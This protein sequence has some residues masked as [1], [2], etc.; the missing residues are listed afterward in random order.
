MKRTTTFEALMVLCGYKNPSAQ[1]IYWRDDRGWTLPGLKEEVEA[2]PLINQILPLLHK[3]R[4][5]ESTQRA[6]QALEGA[7][8]DLA[9]PA[10]EPLSYERAL[11]SFV[12]ARPLIGSLLQ[13][14]RLD[15]IEGDIIYVSFT[16]GSLEAESITD[17]AKVTSIEG[18][19]SQCAGRLIRFAFTVTPEEQTK[20]SPV[21]PP[22]PPTQEI[23]PKATHFLAAEPTHDTP[24]QVFG[25]LFDGHK[26]RAVQG[27]TPLASVLDVLS[28]LGY[29]D[30]KNTF[31]QI[32]DRTPGLVEE[33][34]TYSFGPGQPTPV[35]SSKT[36]L[37]IL[38]AAPNPPDRSKLVR[39]RE[40]AAKTLD[41]VVQG[42][43]TL[44]E[45]IRERG[46]Q[47]QVSALQLPQESRERLS[48]L[49]ERLA[50]RLQDKV[51]ETTI[52][53][54]LIR[55]AELIEGRSLTAIRPKAIEGRW[56]TP[57]QIA[58]KHGVRLYDVGAIIKQ[59]GLK[60]DGE[61]G[62]DGLS[63]PYHTTTEGGTRDVVCF[64]YTETAMQRI[65]ERIQPYQE[66]KP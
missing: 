14:G 13:R 8:K 61:R 27:E 37:K 15:K 6:I 54:I 4:R 32:K 3:M 47:R 34:S 11:R 58:E 53:N 45:E 43:V 59:L 23:A 60:G 40:W 62:I 51:P 64:R 55:S 39:F 22:K 50:D 10:F 30:S 17:P 9:S 16:E 19:F 26:I 35:A 20:L 28:A 24:E 1:L 42:D 63:E 18:F 46:A 56:Y 7:L 12:E 25:E 57:A 52:D 36:L 33:I 29:A 38:A 66:V 48:R 41:R 5:G 2:M 21:L 44:V 31:K 65:V 49:Y